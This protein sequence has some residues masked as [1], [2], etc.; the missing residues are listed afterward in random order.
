MQRGLRSTDPLLFPVF[1][2]GRTKRMLRVEQESCSSSWM[3][4]RSFSIN[5]TAYEMDTSRYELSFICYSF[6]RGTPTI[7]LNNKFLL[8]LPPLITNFADIRGISY[9]LFTGGRSV[10]V[11]SSKGILN[12]RIRYLKIYIRKRNRRKHWKPNARYS[13]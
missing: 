10:Y 5:K 12:I 13:N 2:D 4:Q 11:L 7:Q 9:K 1:K 3:L 6:D 8:L